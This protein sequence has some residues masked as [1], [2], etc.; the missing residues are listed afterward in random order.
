VIEVATYIIL[1]I[2]AVITLLAKAYKSF[3]Y[4]SELLMALL[5]LMLG[6]VIIYYGK[7]ASDIFRDKN[8]Y[9]NNS[10]DNNIR[11]MSFSI[12]GLFLLKGVKIYSFPF[13]KSLNIRKIS[14]K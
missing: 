4:L 10:Y 14:S 2:I 5:Y 3:F 12:G 8:Y 9:E 6:S 1:F 7:C 11:M 13:L